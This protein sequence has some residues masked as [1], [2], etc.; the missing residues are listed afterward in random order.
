MCGDDVG[1][2][3]LGVV[4]ERLMEGLTVGGA[5]ASAL[6]P[7]YATAHRRRSAAVTIEERAGYRR[8]SVAAPGGGEATVLMFLE[9]TGS[10]MVMSPVTGQW[11]IATVAIAMSQ[12]FAAL[13]AQN[14][15]SSPVCEEVAT[16]CP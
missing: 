2:E 9:P 13:S 1:L 8:P 11:P 4:I 7:T 6:T 16:K 3:P 10:C 15:I 12:N 5:G 14:S